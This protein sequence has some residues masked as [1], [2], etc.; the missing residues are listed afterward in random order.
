[1]S[2]TGLLFESPVAGKEVVASF[3]GGH[4]SSDG[5]LM[6]AMGAERQ[7]RLVHRLAGCLSDQRDGKKVRQSI[8]SMLT[9]RIFGVVCGYEDCNDFD[10]LREDPMFKLAVGRSPERGCGLASQPTLSRL[11]NSVGKRELFRMAKTLVEVFIESHRG[12]RVT[13]IILDADGTDDPAHGQ[14][15]FEFFNGHYDCHCFLPLLVYATVESD[16]GSVK[17]SS[18]EQELV[19]ALLRTGKASPGQKALALVRRLVK[20]L[21]AAFPGVTIVFR[22]DSGFALPELYAYLD[23]AGVG[24]V[25]SKGK[26]S[27]LV[28]KSEPYLERAR[29]ARELSGE[30]AR[31]FADFSYRAKSWQCERRVVVKAEVLLDKENPRFV[32]TNLNLNPEALYEFYTERG[33]VENRIKEL[34]DDLFSGRTSCH[35]FL[36]NQFR[37]LLHAAALV[38]I[39]AVRRRLAG[40]GFGK[41]QAGNLRCKLFKVAARVVETTRRIVVHLP[42]SYPWQTTWERLLYPPLPVS[43]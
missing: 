22:G 36:A 10:A 4:L 39:Q 26:N 37:L 19:C 7:I 40:S 12:E 43:A 17:S 15:E 30:A 31:E 33:D 35:R 11:E 38:L 14:Q 13:R 34:K 6:L 9:Q 3:D 28:S 5:G 8:E 42:T 18:R 24:Y 29:R 20:R 27:V 1:M 2:V 23:A 32:V 25:I 21:R 41:A 16:G